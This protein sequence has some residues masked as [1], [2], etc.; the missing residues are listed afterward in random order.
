M[1]VQPVVGSFYQAEKADKNIPTTTGFAQLIKKSI[2][3]KE[4]I[5]ELSRFN[6][7]FSKINGWNI[8]AGD[9]FS[10]DFSGE[11]TSLQHFLGSVGMKMSKNVDKSIKIQIFNVTSITSGFYWKDIAGFNKDL[12]QFVSPISTIRNANS[13]YSYSNISQYI[14]F[15]LSINEVNALLS[16]YCQDQYIP[17]VF[18]NSPIKLPSCKLYNP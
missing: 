4:K 11:F 9:E 1:R 14:S 13:S 16:K 3:V 2:M 10:L 18:V 15:D 7:N 12:K 8:G 5:V 6:F 17:A